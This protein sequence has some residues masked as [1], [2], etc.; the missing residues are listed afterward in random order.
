MPKRAAAAE[1]KPVNPRKKGLKAATY[2]MEPGQID[3]LQREALKRAQ[4]RGS[5][6]ADAS[7]IV[8]EAVDAW[9]AK[10]K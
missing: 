5:F 3:A 2:R 1:T 8:R 6:K 10:R 9:I 7:E 4:E